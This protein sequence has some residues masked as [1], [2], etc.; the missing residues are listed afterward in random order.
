MVRASPTLLIIDQLKGD[1]TSAQE[2]VDE[3]TAS[4]NVIIR[5]IESLE[6]GHSKQKAHRHK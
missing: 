1:M 6:Q 4:M 5:E 2:Q 3:A